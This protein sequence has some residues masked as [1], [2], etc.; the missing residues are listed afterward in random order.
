MISPYLLC[1]TDLSFRY[2]RKPIFEGLSLT[3][4]RGEVVGILGPNGAGKTTLIKCLVGLERLRSGRIFFNEN[5]V[6][7]TPVW[8]RSRLGMA[9]LSQGTSLMPDLT[10][11]ENVALGSGSAEPKKD[12]A[13]VLKRIGMLEEAYKSPDQLSGGQ[14]RLV[15]LGR[16]FASCAP[17]LILDEPFAMLD[18]KTRGQ[19]GELIQYFQSEG[20]TILMTDHDVP[21]TLK[22]V[23]RAL[24]LIDGKV[25]CEGNPAKILQDAF[26]RAHYLG[27]GDTLL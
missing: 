5:D 10:V 25:C 20:R 6:S 4:S 21:S 1:A 19:I 24:V 16:L 26:V 11:L 27:E 22:V 15:E 2:G 3:I 17:L 18:P 14:R 8:K 13:K 9:Y 12:A 23:E 7:A